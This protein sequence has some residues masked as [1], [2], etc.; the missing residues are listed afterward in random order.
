MITKFNNFISE[1]LL[2]KMKGKDKESISSNI[3]KP[4]EENKL[5]NYEYI[6]KLIEYE[7]FDLIKEFV[8]KYKFNSLNMVGILLIEAAEKNKTNIVKYILD[9]EPLDKDIQ[10]VIDNLNNNRYSDSLK[11]LNKYLV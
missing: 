10:Y 3:K 11:L 4:Y 9:L 1:N 5:S 8:E 7:L 6:Y 2:S